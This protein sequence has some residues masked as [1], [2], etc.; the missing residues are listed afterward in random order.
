[1]ILLTGGDVLCDKCKAKIIGEYP[2]EHFKIAFF[3]LK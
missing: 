1:M 3:W 2:E